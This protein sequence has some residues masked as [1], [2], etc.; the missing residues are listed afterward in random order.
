MLTIPAIDILNNK[1]VRLSKG[2]FEQATYYPQPVIDQAKLYESYGFKRLHLV[3]LEASKTG[4]FTALDLIKQIKSETTLEIEFG[5]G[6]RHLEHAETLVHAGVDFV[7]IGSLSVTDKKEFKTIINSIGAE[8]III[9]ADS[10]D[11]VIQVKGWTQSGGVSLKEHITYCNSA[12]IKTFLCT[13]IKKDGMLQGPS[14]GLYKQLQTDFPNLKF[15]AS[16]GISNIEDIKKLHEMNMYATVIGKAIFENKIQL[17]E[18]AEIG[19]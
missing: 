8:K 14:F 10:L 9:A 2:D 5:G 1:I 3:D 6:V 12:G 7:I 15:I 4:T 16:G 11:N 17:K 18:L 19:S 13:D